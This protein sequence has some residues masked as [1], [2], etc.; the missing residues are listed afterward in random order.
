ME[1][2]IFQQQMM[3]RNLIIRNIFHN[4]DW[5]LLLSVRLCLTGL[6]DVLLFVKILQSKAS[7]GKD[8]HCLIN[9]RA[10]PIFFKGSEML[11]EKYPR[12]FQSIFYF[13]KAYNITGTKNLNVN[14]QTKYNAKLPN[15]L[16]KISRNLEQNKTG[17]S[18]DTSLSRNTVTAPLTFHCKRQN[19][20]RNVY[21]NGSLEFEF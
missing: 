9:M 18:P 10:N 14:C 11:M 20:I 13:Q 8:E 15:S 6:P 2:R 17:P 5:T 3:S 16:F 7:K 21:E 4:I 19:S 1:L 12:R